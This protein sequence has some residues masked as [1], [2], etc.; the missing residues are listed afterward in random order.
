[1]GE[2]GVSV[3]TQYHISDGVICGKMAV[4]L[5]GIFWLHFWIVGGNG[6]VSSI[7]ISSQCQTRCSFFFFLTGSRAKNVGNH[8]NALYLLPCVFW[9]F[10]DLK[11]KDEQQQVAVAITLM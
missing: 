2:R 8:M 1:M 6:D 5:F 10:L 4:F 11:S 7:S 3:G 9:M